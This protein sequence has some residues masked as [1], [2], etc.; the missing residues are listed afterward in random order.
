VASDYDTLLAF[1]EEHPVRDADAWLR[2]LAARS[3]RLAARVAAVRL[4]YGADE[5]GCGFE[6]ANLRRLAVQEMRDGNLSVM[7][8]W[9]ADAVRGTSGSSGDAA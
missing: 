3:P 4:S 8:S 6:W 9:A 1:L 7:Q 2:A 5:E